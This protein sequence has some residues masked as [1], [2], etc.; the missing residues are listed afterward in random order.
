[1]I[2]EKTQ[3][4]QRVINRRKVFIRV[5]KKLNR[6]SKKVNIEYLLHMKTKKVYVLMDEPIYLL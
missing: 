2:T 6:L 5:V 3:K 1:M 4:N